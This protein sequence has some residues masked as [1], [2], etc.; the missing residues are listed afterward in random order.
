MD[1]SALQIYDNHR[2]ELIRERVRMPA[3]L[4]SLATLVFAGIDG[5][6]SPI[7]FSAA[8]A[9]YAV[10][11]ATPLLVWLVVAR[12]PRTSPQYVV[13]IGDGAY[14]AGLLT[15]VFIDGTSVSGSAL[16]ITLKIFSTALFIP[17]S[18]R[19]QATSTVLTLAAFGASMLLAGNLPPLGSALSLLL[20]PGIAGAFAVAGTVALDTVRCQL[21]DRSA[22]LTALE[23]MQ[24]R[25]LEELRDRETRLR[26]FVQQMPAALWST[27][28][29]LRITSVLGTGFQGAQAHNDGT[30]PVTLYD[31]YGSD[32]PTFAPIAAHLRALD[33][34]SETFSLEWHGRSYH[35][36]VEPLRDSEGTILGTIG[37]AQDITPQRQAEAERERL[38]LIHEED[39]IVSAA[40]AR[41]GQELIASLRDPA[42]PDRLA[43]LITEAVGCDSSAILLWD[44]ASQSFVH[45]G[46]FGYRPDIG[47]SS[48][49]VNLPRARFVAFYDH[50]ASGEVISFHSK[51][52]GLKRWLSLPESAGITSGMYVALRNGNTM[53]GYIAAHYE[54]RTEGFASWQRR[55]LHGLAHLAALALD[56]AQLVEQ[57]ERAS[58]L[59]SE[60]VA[61]MSHELRTPLNAI[62][63][64]SDLLS[65]GE[66]GKLT[67]EQRETLAKVSQCAHDLFDLIS[68]TLDLSRLDSGKLPLDEAWIG[69]DHLLAD[70]E[71]EAARLRVKA[72]VEI[73]W[74]IQ[75]PLP[76]LFVD[77]A[78]VKVVLK[79]LIG[80]AVKFTE[81]GSILVQ[82][83]ARDA[84]LQV[85]VRDTGP[86]ID[87]ARIEEMFEP[88]RQGDSSN[89]RSHGGVGLGLHIVRRLLDLLEGS[90]EVESALGSGTTFTVW[91]PCDRTEVDSP[92]LLQGAT[93]P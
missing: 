52:K 33:G 43:R 37:V 32:D 58:A 12:F 93:R 46:A 60:F 82:A 68:A 90:V 7:H 56:N 8:L 18:A 45:R 83:Q 75:S 14:T 49:V 64:Y 92:P 23:S 54:Q 15:Q 88:F 51:Q 80:N 19:L 89:T 1:S 17:W 34:N 71:S 78:K 35:A 30:P 22:R 59:K 72:G 24:R 36:H 28:R 55:A 29:D 69:G 39:A 21:V 3:C 79:N 47:E 41:V 31:Y 48:R 70:V 42:L 61:T 4:I 65:E 73:R 53:V 77:A 63:G 20:M 26:F 25:Q 16:A 81:R 50:L 5:L 86:G 91:L 87:P 62:I 66:F 10:E 85:V 38:A 84:G 27:D 2:D 74:D 67:D 76:T 57:F 9:A 13:L 6:V 40:L 11:I 44:E